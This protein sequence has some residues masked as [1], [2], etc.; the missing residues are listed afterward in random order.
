VVESEYLK[1]K[2]RCKMSEHEESE[3]LERIA[4]ADR[5]IKAAADRIATA[6]TPASLRASYK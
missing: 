1:R 3:A 2:G 5:A 6:I 4:A